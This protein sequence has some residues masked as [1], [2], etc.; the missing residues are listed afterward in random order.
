[1]SFT[2]RP[3]T[4][5]SFDNPLSPRSG[6]KVLRI[7]RRARRR[8]RSEV[9]AAKHAITKQH[10][11]DAA[12][13]EL[14]NPH[15][16]TTATF[17]M[18]K[19]L[20]FPSTPVAA[21]TSRSSCCGKIDLTTPLLSGTSD[22]GGSNPNHTNTNSKEFRQQSSDSSTMPSRNS[23]TSSV[24]TEEDEHSSSSSSSVFKATYASK[25]QLIGSRFL[26]AV[27]VLDYGAAGVGKIMH[28]DVLDMAAV[29]PGVGLVLM[30]ILMTTLESIAELFGTAITPF[31]YRKIY[32]NDPIESRQLAR[33]AIRIY[34][35][36]NMVAFVLYPILSGYTWIGCNV[37]LT[38]LILL[39]SLRT[40]QYSV[41]NQVGDA[42]VQMAKPHWLRTFA[43]TSMQIPGFDVGVYVRTQTT[44][45]TLSAHIS[46]IVF[47]V[48]PVVG[49]FYFSVQNKPIPRLMV[50]TIIAFVVMVVSFAFWHKEQVLTCGVQSEVID[51]KHTVTTKDEKERN[52]DVPTTSTTR[53]T[54]TNNT[55]TNT[56]IDSSNIR[57]TEEDDKNERKRSVSGD[58]AMSDDLD[59]SEGCCNNC[60][61][62]CGCGGEEG[63]IPFCQLEPF[64]RSLI[65]LN[66]IVKVVNEQV[67]NA[68]SAVVLISLGGSYRTLFLFGS[69]GIGMIYLLFKIGTEHRRMLTRDRSN[70]T[71]KQQIINNGN[72]NGDRNCDRNGDGNGDGNANANEESAKHIRQHSFLLRLSRWIFVVCLICVCLIVSASLLLTRPGLSIQPLF[73]G[74][75]PSPSTYVNYTTPSFRNTT[76]YGLA[77][78]SSGYGC[79]RAKTE[80]SSM[81]A[82]D[83]TYM[84]MTIIAIIVILP[85]YPAIKMFDV[86][87][88]AFLMDYERD[89]PRVVTSMSLWIN[90]LAPVCHLI[91]LGINTY[92][93]YS[94]GVGDHS[95]SVQVAVT[96]VM[97]VSVLILLVFYYA[98]LDRCCLPNK[99]SVRSN[100]QKM[101]HQ[102]HDGLEKE[103]ELKVMKKKEFSESKEAKKKNKK[104]KKESKTELPGADPGAERPM[105]NLSHDG[106]RIVQLNKI[107]RRES[108]VTIARTTF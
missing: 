104:K 21:G 39:A 12:V 103:L 26:I 16:C 62:C 35:F 93:M 13:A 8:Q 92:A 36:S 33:F 1:M 88:D 84:T 94:T 81:D 59:S 22:D 95:G 56:N 55:N 63:I 49:M 90:V 7:A 38:M 52:G 102:I 40:L 18:L 27:F 72:G 37:N 30:D 15:C 42:A 105:E 106:K 6:K 58:S 11:Y 68:V 100:L 2:K 83:P 45:D 61:K 99:C 25:L 47:V 78:S 98:V 87:Y 73:N 46:F 50:A 44:E 32:P 74:D 24:M 53:T 31:I 5:H 77:P 20:T 71:K 65:C 69:A 60:L 80:G 43:G 17:I 89:R 23:L 82:Q 54:T 51:M 86:E 85:L 34:A 79:Q 48:A 41:F 19:M 29:V 70:Y 10:N 107:D 91:M 3:S 76:S 66:V 108:A 64:Q 28:L 101:D 57:I 75:A 67:T 9:R 97:G 4:T 96:M 14:Q